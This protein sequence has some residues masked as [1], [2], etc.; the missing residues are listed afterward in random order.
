MLL[1]VAVVIIGDVAVDHFGHEQAPVRRTRLAT[2]LL[3]GVTRCRVRSTGE[4]RGRSWS[5]SSRSSR[6][7]LATIKEPICALMNLETVECRYTTPV[8]PPSRAQ[9]LLYGEALDHNCWAAASQARY[10]TVWSKSPDWC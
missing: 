6:R 2:Y 3:L 4:K 7:K 8:K 10:W 5:A 9:T 1:A